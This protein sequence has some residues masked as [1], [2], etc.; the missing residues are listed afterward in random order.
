M[1]EIPRYVK[2]GIVA[3]VAVVIVIIG[4]CATSAI[5]RRSFDI[6]E[7][8]ETRSVDA[9]PTEYSPTEETSKPVNAQEG[10]EVD[11][12]KAIKDL[13]GL[14]KEGCSDSEY[15]VKCALA[16]LINSPFS[17]DVEKSAYEVKFVNNDWLI[18]FDCKDYSVYVKCDSEYYQPVVFSFTRSITEEEREFFFSLGIATEVDNEDGT[19][20][21]YYT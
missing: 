20:T 11:A 10:M 12:P 5:I 1:L 17:K 16:I 18:E 15:A 7:I 9:E 2:I 4:I 14:E 8:A 6:Y 13:Y 19:Y 21:I 3:I